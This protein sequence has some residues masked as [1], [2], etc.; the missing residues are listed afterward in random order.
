MRVRLTRNAR[1]DLRAIH[2]WIARDDPD[3]ASRFAEELRSKAREIGQRPLGYPVAARR[4]GIVL[5]KRSWRNYVIVYRV[6]TEIE[7]VGFFHVK[8]D[9]LSLLDNL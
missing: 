6:K 7:I 4:R 3:T 2:D 8:R 9:Y 1:L 5:R